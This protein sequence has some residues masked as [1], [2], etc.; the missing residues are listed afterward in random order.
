M[1]GW[2][3]WSTIGVFAWLFVSIVVSVG[4]GRV[5]ALMR[6]VPEGSGPSF[7]ASYGAAASLIDAA[8]T[9][10]IAT[11]PR[12]ARRKILLVDDDPALRLL[13]RTTLAAEAYA[14][15]EAASATEAAHVAR[16]WR[17]FLVVLDVD[18]PDAN[19]VAFCAELKRKSAFG[20]PDVII[21]TG[22]ETS[23]EE[24]RRAGADG[25]VR[26]PFS[27]LE[28]IAAVDRIGEGEPLLP[29]MTEA[30]SSDQLLAY[31]RDLGHIVEVERAQRRLLQQAYRQTVAALTDALEAKSEGA[32]LHSVRVHR[33]A[34]ELTE[35]FEPRLL[36]DPSL[37]YGFLLHDIGKIAIPDAILEKRGPLTA[38]ERRLMQRHPLIGAEI[39][40]EIPL[41]N[42]AGRQVV[43]AHH[44]RWD[45]QGYPHGVAGATIP[46]GARI[47]AVADALDAMTTDRPYRRRLEW[48][49]AAEEILRESGRQFDPRVVRAFALAEQ[50]LRRSG[51]ELARTA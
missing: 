26:K 23:L 42:G 10:G 17:P 4:F 20:A 40:R 21:L 7:E 12:L 13:L 9:G 38:G 22:G 1:P 49:T 48:E 6:R 8:P 31:A 45:G 41:L 43:E 36:D 37:E 29:A 25:L 11:P 39:L 15:E 46:V 34:L 24:A 18:L 3:V 30:A 14:V 27:P 5:A 44:E 28:L 16:F 51:R 32:G 2:A 35:A 47:F 33:F 50:R 19:G